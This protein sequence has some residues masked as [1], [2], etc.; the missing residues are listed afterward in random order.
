MISADG[1]KEEGADARAIDLVPRR[2]VLVVQK[3]GIEMT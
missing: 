2:V 3:R 1:G